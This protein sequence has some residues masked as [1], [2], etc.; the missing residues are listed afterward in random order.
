MDVV[1]SSPSLHCIGCNATLA[2]IASESS[3]DIP[4]EMQYIVYCSECGCRYTA[5]YR[6]IDLFLVDTKGEAIGVVQICTRCHETYRDGD[7][8]ICSSS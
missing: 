6:R 8:H 1:K 3:Q 7:F 5:V 4:D 2:P